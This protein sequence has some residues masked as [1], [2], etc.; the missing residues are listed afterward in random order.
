MKNER[1]EIGAWYARVVI[2]PLGNVAQQVTLFIS[3]VSNSSYCKRVCS[4]KL[5]PL[6]AMWVRR[7]EVPIFWSEEKNFSPNTVGTVTSKKV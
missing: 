7:I 4:D 2:C 5:L 1:L 6:S 3:Q